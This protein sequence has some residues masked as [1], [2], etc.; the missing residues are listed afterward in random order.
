MNDDETREV[1][2]A[3]AMQGLI[4]SGRLITHNGLVQRPII[5]EAF[6]IANAMLEESNLQANKK[7]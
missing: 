4:A 7:S 3:F 5:D 2:A 1:F 6:A